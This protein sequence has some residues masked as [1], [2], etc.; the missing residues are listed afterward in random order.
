MTFAEEISLSGKPVS[1]HGILCR[2]QIQGVH[3]RGNDIKVSLAEVERRHACRGNSFADQITEPGNWPL[4][5]VAFSDQGWTILGTARVRA[6]AN[7]TSG[8][9]YFVA[10]GQRR[11]ARG[12]ILAP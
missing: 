6:V 3:Q 9:E 7:G 11:R 8:R 4:P 1:R 10:S 5:Q 12:G 2:R